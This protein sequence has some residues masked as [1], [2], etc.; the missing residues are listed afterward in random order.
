MF[1]RLLRLRVCFVWVRVACKHTADHA[2]DRDF[3]TWHD[4]RYVYNLLQQ[5]G[6]L[7]AQHCLNA[8]LQD[9]YFNAVD[10]A[11]LAEQ[12]DT[13]ERLAMAESGEDTDEYKRFIEVCRR[14]GYVVC[15]G[16]VR[17]DELFLAVLLFFGVEKSFFVY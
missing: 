17:I 15:V 8:L 4:G 16:G 3:I 12:L 14:E 10:L 9:Q 2:R 7:C 5:E 11:N 6:Y 13:E 1:I